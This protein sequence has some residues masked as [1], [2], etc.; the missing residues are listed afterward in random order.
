[1]N[2]PLSLIAEITHRC[3]LHC[4]YC[5]NPFVMSGKGDEL[6]TQTWIDVF[7]QAAA[8]GVLQVDL[9]GGEPVARVDHVELVS[10]ARESGLYVNLIT[11]G[12]GLSPEKL[13]QL[14]RA[15]LDHVQLS[16]QDSDAG[17]ADEIAGATVHARKLEIAQEIR[18]RRMGFTVNIVVHRHNLQ[19][20]PQMIAMAEEVGAH[21]VE[22]AHVQY[23]GWAFRNR[24]NLLPTRGQLDSSLKVVQEAQARL[25]GRMRIDYIVPDYYAK[26]PK[27]C[28]GG[29]G[30]KTL[31]ITPS[32]EALP[33]HAAKVI[34]EMRFENVREHKLRWIWQESDSFLRF[35]GEAWMPEPCRSCDR[36]T[37]D[38]GGCR[39]QAFLLTG[40][41]HATDPVCSL[42]PAHKEVE[43]VVEQINAW[44]GSPAEGSEPA[45]VTRASWE[46]RQ[47][48]Q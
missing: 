9:T 45:S 3:P 34:P 42:A 32:G 20:L 35:R 38:F 19:R 30:R 2:G 37:R 7:Q 11:S 39:C 25:E 40:D 14:A 29:W 16:F 22:I 12:I 6:S 10:A 8:M 28:M 26:F 15:R 17:P 46:Y 48:P 24:E 43:E 47:N 1:M 33:C 27:A 18:R 13:E 36:R 4:V 41:S 5:S 23:Y 21:K 44:R 31:L